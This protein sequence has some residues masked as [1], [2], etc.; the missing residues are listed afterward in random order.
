M[1]LECGS[2]AGEPPALPG[3]CLAGGARV[4]LVWWFCCGRAACAPRVLFGGRAG[5]AAGVVVLLRASRPR[6]QDVVWWARSRWV[7]L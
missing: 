2:V 4:L 6:S 3:C 7:F 1:L 5:R